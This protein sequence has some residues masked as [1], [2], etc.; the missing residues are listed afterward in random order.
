MKIR[1]LLAGLA[2]GFLILVRATAQDAQP[3]VVAELQAVIS[4]VITKAR[5]GQDSAADLAPEIAAFDAIVAKYRDNDAGAAA[6]ALLVKASLFAQVI[7]DEPAARTILAQVQAD[8][9]GTE[10]AQN[11][12]KIIAGLDRAAAAEAAAAALVGAA[13]PELDFIWSSKEGLANLSD[14]RGQVV[15]LDFWA[16]WCGPCVSSFPQ[17]RELTAHYAGSP[18]A[19]VGVTSLQGAVMG[20]EAKP[21]NTK[22]DPEREMA[23]MKDYMKAKDITWTVVFSEQPVFNEDYGIQGIPYVAIIAPDGTVRHTGLHPASPLAEKTE[24]IDAILREFKL[25]VPAKG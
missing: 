11:A 15:V 9:P 24:K 8:F 22:C 12:E 4:Q 14:L 16:T 3:P 21:I 17:V 13:A 5:A 18:V 10:A 20:L 23:L 1:S 7:N 2:L 6:E 19:V 25:P